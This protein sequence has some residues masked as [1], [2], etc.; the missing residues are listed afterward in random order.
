MPAPVTK[1]CIRTYKSSNA[2]ST[3]TCIW[4]TTF[5]SRAPL[6]WKLRPFTKDKEH[7]HFTDSHRTARHHFGA[8]G[9]VTR[10]NLRNRT[11]ARG[12]AFASADGVHYLRAHLHGCPRDVA[13]RLEPAANQRAPK[14]V[15]YLGNLAASARSRASFW[16]GGQF[17]PRN[18]LLLHSEMARRGPFSSRCGL[19][20]LG[21]VDVGCDAPL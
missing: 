5:F 8:S 14:R 21:D 2:I 7:A 15:T 18:R 13:G 12:V 19:D 4:K 9:A 6:N 20:V 1:P 16:L 11:G 3:S 10:G 17:H